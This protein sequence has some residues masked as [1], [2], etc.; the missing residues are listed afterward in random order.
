MTL[1][2]D[3]QAVVGR[4]EELAR[5]DAFLQS[6]LAGQGGI[7]LITGEPGAGKSTLLGEFIRRTQSTHPDLFF[8][9][10]D[11]N[12]QTGTVDPYLPFREIL[13]ELTANQDTESVTE[14]G[15]TQSI[16]RAAGRVLAE[17]GPDLIDLFVPG[18]ALITR[19]SSQAASKL[20]GRHKTGND[21]AGQQ[22]EF[23]SG[24]LAQDH[25]LEQYTNVIRAF[26]QQQPLVLVVDDLH[27]ADEA[28]ISLLFHLSR[29]IAD[30]RVLVV[31]AYRANEV[32]AGR[33]AGRH[34]LEAPMNEL[35]RYHG[36]IWV[37][38]EESRESAGRAFIDELLDADAN[39]LD[40]DFRQAL[41]DRTHGHALFTVELLRYL[42]ESGFVSRNDD[43][44]W[45][46]QADL[47]W[48]GMPARVEGVIQE[49][50]ARLSHDEREL[51]SAASVLGESFYAELLAGITEKQVRE[52]VRALSGSLSG[53]HALVTAIGIE[54]LAGKRLAEYEFRHNL[55]HSFFYDALDSVERSMLHEAAANALETMFDRDSALIAVQ[56]ARHFNNAGMTQE[57]AG[58]FL[59]A[60][61]EA[62]RV[63]AH[64][65]A[66]SHFAKALDLMTSADA[67]GVDEATNVVAEAAESLGNVQVLGG[68]FA[69]A[70]AQYRK[71]QEFRPQHDPLQP[72]RLLA[73]IATTH[74]REHQHDQALRLLNEA[75]ELLQ[76][77]H[78][79]ND[80]DVMHQWLT[81]QASLLWLYYWQGDTDGM[82]QVIDASE[83]DFE[84]YGTLAHKRRFYTGKAGL[85]NRLDRFVPGAGTLAASDLGLAASMSSNSI[86]DHA[87]G[88]FGNGFVH[89]LA[90]DHKIALE[91]ISSALELTIRCG[92]RTLQAR[93]LT[94]LTVLHRKLDQPDQVIHFGERAWEICEALGMQ[95]YVGVI[96]ACRSWL[97]WR[98]G[99]MTEAEKLARQALDSWQEHASR[100]PFKWLALLQL[101][102]IE[103][104]QK[105]LEQAVD[106]ARS[107]LTPAHSRL[108]GGIEG[109]LQSAIGSFESGA[110]DQAADE[111][112]NAINQARKSAYL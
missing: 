95:E 82:Q 78:D 45:A 111:L 35:K 103:L 76:Q 16:L 112:T 10:G 51:L 8:A 68:E 44:R 49:R 13:A 28:S 91:L 37:D 96:L 26:S 84:Q 18:G 83:A 70:R 2:A 50:T 24:N 23:E 39:D 42:K 43:E 29:R 27:W 108:T 4:S 74:V 17:H 32:S 90:G 33:G 53:K 22:Q 105:Q 79:R 87:D 12:P 63:F 15:K 98:D 19:V 25:L 9:L 69:A 57:A 46:A 81:L 73:R 14:P 97:A 61:R 62:L 54:R 3:T 77:D 58:Y 5:L 21:Q 11:C 36:D 80:A 102:D 30:R 109:S 1:S 48:D 66:E 64:T 65:E 106:H 71:A 101:I 110:N 100:Y 38:L 92:N 75:G 104:K 31:G 99:K 34:P 67:S 56:L 72:V 86:A 40:E 107:L 60:G 41:F 59:Q 88:K 47:R 55:I 6:A 85:G 93:C 7:C 20:R 94:Y 52:V 89:L